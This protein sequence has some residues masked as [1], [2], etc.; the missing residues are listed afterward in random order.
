MPTWFDLGAVFAAAFLV[1]FVTTPLVRRFALARGLVVQPDERRVHQRPTAQLGGIAMM[2]GFVVA[3]GTAWAT[4]GFNAIFGV[5]LQMLGLLAGAGIVWAV[6]TFDDVREMSAPAKTAGVVLG[7]CVL[8]WSG[9]NM[10]FFRIP[11]AG[12]IVLSADWAPLLTVLWVFGLCTAVNLI[13]G[14]DGLAAGIVAIAAGSFAAYGHKLLTSGLISTDNPSVLIAVIVVGLCLGFL[15]HNFH[16]ARIFMG[17]G[18]A[19]LLGVLMAA[20][21]ML[22]GGQS[23]ES[24]SGQTYFFF[25]PLFIPLFILGVPILDTAFA[26]VRRAR[27]R[28]GVAT[29]DKDHLHHRLMRLGHGQRR[30]VV[31]LWLWTALLS[32]FVLY[33]AYTGKGDAIV[34]ILMLALGLLLY[35]LFHP[36]RR[37]AREAEREGEGTDAAAPERVEGLPSSD[38]G[39]PTQVP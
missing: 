23:D 39:L 36:G 5:H 18:G 6:G 1:T 22:V 26:I 25:A 10:Q 16:P 12:T 7:A 15:P 31:I 14:L 2:A 33:P 30:S 19:L 24:F 37:Q 20:S 3:L 17:D 4:G 11:F 13:D 27:H 38:Q 32:A 8:F 34:P 21:T 35:T 9:I 28:S 29:A